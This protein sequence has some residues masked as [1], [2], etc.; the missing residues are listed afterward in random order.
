MTVSGVAFDCCWLM[1][2]DKLNHP[3]M[4]EVMKSLN[5][6]EENCLPILLDFKYHIQGEYM[7][8]LESDSWGKKIFTHFMSIGLIEYR[9]S[10]PKDECHECL[11]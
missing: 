11:K 5:F 6:M 10:T 7:R 9:T 1:N 4:C 2:L 8:N 3:K